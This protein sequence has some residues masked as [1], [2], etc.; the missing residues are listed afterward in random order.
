L[1]GPLRQEARHRDGER[2]G[3]YL[4]DSA[5]LGVLWLGYPVFVLLGPDGTGAWT[6]TTTTGCLAVLDLVAKVAYGFL[7]VEASRRAADGDL[8]RHE[9]SPTLVSSHG[10]PSDAGENHPEP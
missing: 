2:R 1:F 4:R 8:A 10:V 6:S 9:V 3:G 5:V 7:A